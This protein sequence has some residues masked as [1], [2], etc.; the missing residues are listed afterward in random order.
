LLLIDNSL[1][2]KNPLGFVPYFNF[3]AAFDKPQALATVA[4]PLV[5]TGILFESDGLTGFPTLGATMDDTIGTAIGVEFLRGLD[6]EDTSHDRRSY[7]DAEGRLGKQLVLEF[8]TIH[9]MNDGDTENYGLGMRYQQAL[10]NAWSFRI[11]LMNGWIQNGEDSFG[12]KIELRRR[13]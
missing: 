13:F 11:D 6:Y 7:W 2:T 9:S 5:N 10:N 3:F 4:N 8:A 1:I 12:S